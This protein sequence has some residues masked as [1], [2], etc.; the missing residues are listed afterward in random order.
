VGGEADAERLDPGEVAAHGGVALADEVGVDVEAGVGDNACRSPG[1][2]YR[3][4]K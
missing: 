4:W 2:F 1:P 3:P